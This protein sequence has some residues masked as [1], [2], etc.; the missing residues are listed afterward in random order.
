MFTPLTPKGERT[1]QHLIDV[2]LERFERDGFAATPMRAIAADAGVSLGLAYRYFDA[3]EAI[4]LAFY[5]QVARD[6]LATPIEGTTL[7]ARF[8]SVMQSKLALVAHRRRAMGS[9]IAAMLDPDGPVGLLSPAT[10][11][12]RRTTQNVLRAAVTGATGL[13][14]ASVEPLVRLGWVGHALLL[15]AWIQRPTAAMVLV[16]RVSA[17][18]D[19]LVPLLALPPVAIALAAAADAIGPFAGEPVA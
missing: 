2:A 8:R 19:L 18:L 6:L 16:D 13:P 17:A 5:E 14:P 4:V 9:V 1:R 10:A 7:G 15:L 12:V 11:E 3:K